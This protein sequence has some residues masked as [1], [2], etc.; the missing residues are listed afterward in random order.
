MPNHL[1]MSLSVTPSATISTQWQSVEAATVVVL[2][3]FGLLFAFNLE[4]SPF[5]VPN[6]NQVPPRGLKQF[7]LGPETNGRDV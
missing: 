5:G 3:M 4:A 2:D 7:W 1:L 6:Q